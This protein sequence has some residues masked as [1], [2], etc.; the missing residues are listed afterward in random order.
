MLARDQRVDRYIDKAAPWARPL[1]ELLREAVH[2]GCPEAQETI[3]WSVP[4]FEYKGVF[5]SLAAFKQHARLHFWKTSL[6]RSE[7]SAAGQAALDQLDRMTTVDE[8][9]N[10]KTLVTLVKAAARLH[11]AGV[12]VV[13]T[14]PVAKPPLV[15]PPF[16]KAA[17]AQVPAAKAAFDEFSPSHRR[18]YLEWV[19]E[20]KT[21]DTRD[22]RMAKTLEQLSGGKSRHW[23]FQRAKA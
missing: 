19:T 13:R 12:K 18:E 20:A 3:K 16:F 4:H 5:C 23:K 15:V 2:A 22:R 17:L 11:D 10:H 8:V 6:L 1:L 7:L 9:P 14:R 21:Q